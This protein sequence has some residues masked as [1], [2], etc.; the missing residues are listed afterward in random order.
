MEADR[1]SLADGCS[2]RRADGRSSGHQRHC[3][4]T[5][6]RLSLVRLPAGVCPATTIAG[7]KGGR[8][9][10]G[11]D[12]KADITA[13]TAAARSVALPISGRV[14]RLVKPEIAPAWKAYCG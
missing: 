9:S 5:E 14:M 12:T 13:P 3:A 8:K 2:G 1:T 7:G 4:C 6:E 10:V 11:F